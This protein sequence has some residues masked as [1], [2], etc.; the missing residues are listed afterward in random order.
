[1]FPLTAQLAFLGKVASWAV[2]A[3]EQQRVLQGQLA[4]Q[5][6]WGGLCSPAQRSPAQTSL[7]PW[8]KSC[9]ATC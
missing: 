3:V 9:R 7:C 5:S 6:S 1:M 2:S 8:V 4:G